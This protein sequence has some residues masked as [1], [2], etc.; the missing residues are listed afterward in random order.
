MAVSQGM[1]HSVVLAIAAQ[2]DTDQQAVAHLMQRTQ[3]AVG[4]G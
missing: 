4:R 3:A 2:R 1:D